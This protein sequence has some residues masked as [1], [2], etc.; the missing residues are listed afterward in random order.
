[1]LSLRELERAARLLG[2]I[3]EDTPEAERRGLIGA[4]KSAVSVQRVRDTR[5]VDNHSPLVAEV[6][7]LAEA[8]RGSGYRTF[9]AVSIPH[10]GPDQSGL[11]QGFDRFSAPME[12]ERDASDSVARM[13]AFLADAH[14][15]PVF[16]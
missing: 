3:D 7:T 15:E 13:L 1:M 5:I 11:A 8:F 2:R 10:L 16:A 12:G 9:A 6:A 4:Y 14:S